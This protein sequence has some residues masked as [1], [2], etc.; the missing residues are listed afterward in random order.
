MTA[1][2]S[3]PAQPLVSV[4][5][6]NFN[7]HAWMHRCLD[8]LKAQTI[9][10][11][12]EVFVADN[13]STDRS[14]ILS[15]ELLAGWSNGFFIQNG[16]NVGFAAGTSTSVARSRGKYLFFL[17][18]DVWLEPD[19]LQKLVEAAD[20]SGVGAAGAV[21]LDY[22]TD[23]VQT[24]GGVGF[25]LFGNALTP[26]AGTVP[27]HLFVACGFYFV[28]TDLF[29]RLG[30][31]DPVSFLYGE[32]T[33]LS[34]RVWIAGETIIHVPNARIHHRGAFIANPKGG[35]RIVEVRTNEMKR[36]YANRN[37]LL[38]LLKNCRHVLLVLALTNILW[39]VAETMIG[40]VLL[41]RLSFFRKTCLAVLADCWRLRDHIFEQRRKINLFR[42]RGDFWML[43]FFSPRFA[44]WDDIARIF[45]LG[46]PKVDR[47]ELPKS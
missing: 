41:R 1:T 32:E 47:S 30:G 38:L 8:S 11:R 44:R 24:R 36:F 10:K 5:I 26:R 28:R 22:D 9:F 18:P 13:A 3:E 7:G 20:N 31:F 42:K 12:I 17:N 14:D 27:D 40:C 39:M 23:N 6:V 34:W 15:E 21:V 16:K 25:D 29:N 2:M 43:R 4:V 37:N 46:L 35:T 19:C 33:D 45:R